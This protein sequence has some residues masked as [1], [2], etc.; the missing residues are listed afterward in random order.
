[1]LLWYILLITKNK[2]SK[3]AGDVTSLN[4]SFDF[5]FFRIKQQI[6]NTH[7]FAQPKIMG[8]Y[9]RIPHQAIFNIFYFTALDPSVLRNVFLKNRFLMIFCVSCPNV[10]N[11]EM[12]TLKN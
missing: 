12:R 9:I 7:Y 8:L 11:K 6:L 2:L 10:P 5:S 1:M 4:A 3:I